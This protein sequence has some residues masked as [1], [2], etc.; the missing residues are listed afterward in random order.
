MRRYVLLL[1]ISGITFSSCITKKDILVAEIEDMWALQQIVDD[2]LIAE[3][4]KVGFINEEIQHMLY[5]NLGASLVSFS[6]AAQTTFF[7]E[8]KI[9]D[10]L[11]Y[12]KALQ[13]NKELKFIEQEETKVLLEQ[14]ILLRSKGF[15]NLFFNAGFSNK[16]VVFLN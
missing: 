16:L 8:R 9:R 1:I 10:S 3:T 13:K 7:K 15:E 11:Q 14:Q 4:D 12:I 5:S 6:D 2:Q